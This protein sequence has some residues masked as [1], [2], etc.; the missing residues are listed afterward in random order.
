MLIVGEIINTSRRRI[1]EAVEK[2]DSAFIVQVAMWIGKPNI[3][4]GW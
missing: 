4:A 3:Y 2:Q 1:A